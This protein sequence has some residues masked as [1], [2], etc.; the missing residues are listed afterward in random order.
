MKRFGLNSGYIGVDRRRDEAGIAPL[1]KAYLERTRGGNYSPQSTL[2]LDL[3]PN[4]AVA[5]SLR[6]LRTSYSG[7]AI[8]VRRSSDNTEQ[9]IGFVAGNLDTASLASFC[10]GTNGFVTTWYDQ[11][12]NNR[13]VIQT[14]A[15]YQPRIVNNGVVDSTG[16]RPSILHQSGSQEL[17][18]PSIYSIGN[19]FSAFGTIKFDSLNK[20]WM[21][22]PG[23]YALYAELNTTYLFFNTV[24]H[25]FGLQLAQPTLINS[26]NLT[27]YKN[28]NL[29]GTVSGASF[30]FQS[31]SGEAPTWNMVG[32]ISET[33]IYQ[34][35]QS[36]NRVA[37][38]TDIKTYYGIP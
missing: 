23:G 24:S 10:A 15:V 18:L 2:L 8:R 21:G 29:V 13:N 5:Y 1:Q 26:G 33:I 16:I 6:K 38:E 27:F 31:L 28:S 9:D 17:K 22:R 34:F 3:Y 32:Y 12:G 36:S 7:S 11:S 25:S 14:T 30:D 4:A 35:D 37:I 19:I 20:E